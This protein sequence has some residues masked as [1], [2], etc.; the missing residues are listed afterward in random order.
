MYFIL[1]P[2]VMV[3]DLLK[4]D[5]SGEEEVHPCQLYEKL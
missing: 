2:Y 5:M 3:K 1:Y 4:Y